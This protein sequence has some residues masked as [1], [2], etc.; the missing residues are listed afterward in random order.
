MPTALNGRKEDGAEGHRASRP[1]LR[2]RT[3]ADFG[4]QWTAYPDNSGY[5]G[6][7]EILRD[8]FGPL[9]DVD[10]LKGTV[11]ADIGAGTGR[12]TSILVRCG[13]AKV[14][15]VEPSRAFDVLIRNTN[16]IRDSIEY[17]N[18]GGEQLITSQPL[19]FAF[20][21]GVIHH[22]PDPVPVVKAMH[23]ALRPGG[24]VGVWL[25]G[26]EGNEAY[27]TV[28]RGLS[29]VTKNL[30]H[31]ALAAVVWLVYGPALVY[32]AAC[33]VFHLPMAGYIR[34]VFAKLTPDKRRLVIYDQLNPSYAKYYREQEV[35]A[36]LANAGFIDIRLFHRHGYSWTALGTKP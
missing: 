18:A 30:P 13:V 11:V 23:D 7:L 26:H 28:L 31:V 4:D 36:L 6:S 34:K 12:F 29:R 10:S 21:F 35:R 20:S 3:I 2:E 27:V 5:Y 8:I 25:Y 33:S 1:E 9:L 15:A 24:C 17:L 14:I 19:D 22:I 16:A 32:M